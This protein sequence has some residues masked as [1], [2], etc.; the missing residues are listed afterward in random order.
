[1]DAVGYLAGGV[2]HDFNNILTVISGHSQVLQSRPHPDADLADGLSS[3][4]LAADRAAHLT[5]QLL[6][7]SRKQIMQFKPLDLNDVVEEAASLLARVIGEDIELELC[8]AAAPAFVQGDETMLVQVLMNLAVNARDAM[9]KGGKL[10]MTSELCEFSETEARRQPEA[11][12][13]KFIHLCV[14]DNGRGISPQHLPHIFEPFFTTK[15]LGSGTGLG[16]AT[17]YGIVQQHQGW[18]EVSSRLDTGTTFSIFLPQ[19]LPPAPA[20]AEPLPAPSRPGRGE[21]VLLAEDELPVRR[22]ARSLLQRQGYH[23]LEAASGV[24]ACS[25]WEQHAGEVKVLLTDVIMPGGLS[26]LE[27]ARDLLEKKPGLK[28]IFTSGYSPDKVGLEAGLHQG[29]TFLQKPYSM[30]QLLAALRQ[31]LAG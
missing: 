17:V 12:V 14:A 15:E 25:L 23:V 31:S 29:M 22:L 26:G 11:R 2:A 3:I 28:V 30:Q 18:I 16:L 6:T 27:L 24:E 8:C 9:P 5:R 4:I 7:F 1:M 13:G 10:T 19:A 21:T 20:A